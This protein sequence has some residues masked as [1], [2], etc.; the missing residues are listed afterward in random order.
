MICY[1][2]FR[3][4]FI[5]REFPNFDIL[6]SFKSLYGSFTS[7]NFSEDSQIVCIC[8]HDDAITVLSLKY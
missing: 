3:G 1:I 4:Y 6:F 2:D 7:F 8:G 5:I